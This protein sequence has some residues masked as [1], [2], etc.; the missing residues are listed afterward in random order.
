MSSRRV[1]SDQR[2]RT[3]TSCDVCKSRK[4]KCHRQPDESSCRY[5][6]VHALPCTTNQ[7]RKKRL[8]GSFESVGT[9]IQL[10]ETL[11]KGLVPE[12]DLSSLEDIRRVGSSMGIPLPEDADASVLQKHSASTEEPSTL[13]PDQQGSSQYTGPLSSYN[14]HLKLRSLL[15]DRPDPSVFKLF[16]GNASESTHP[17]EL[18]AIQQRLDAGWVHPMPSGTSQGN[19]ATADPI[20]DMTLDLRV[21]D[22]MVRTYLEAVQPDFPVLHEPTFVKTYE[23]WRRAPS[24]DDRV[25]VCTLLCMSMLASR[26]SRVE[27]TVQQQLEWWRGIQALLPTVL[28]TSSIGSVQALLLAALHLQNT[29]RRDACWN[30][31]GAAVRIAHAI[32]LHNDEIR[33]LEPPIYREIRKMVFWALFSFEQ[34]QISSYDRPSAIDYLQVKVGY[35][36]EKICGMSGCFPPDICRC[37]IQ[38]VLL[39]ACACRA[40]KQLPGSTISERVPYTPLSPAASALRDLVKW[41]ESLPPHLKLEAIDAAP[42]N[43]FRVILTLHT[44]YHYNTIV[45]SRSALLHRATLL[46]QS[47][48]APISKGL[49]T[50]SEACRDSSRAIAECML[51][52]HARGKFNCAT[53]YMSSALGL[54]LDIICSVRLG[55]DYSGQMQ[56]LLELANMA[57]HYKKTPR[58]PETLYEWTRLITEL[59]AMVQKHCSS[60]SHRHAEG[61]QRS[62]QPATQDACLPLDLR[63]QN[64]LGYQGLDPQ[65]ASGSIEQQWDPFGTGFD[66]SGDMHD[67][68]WGDIEAML[69]A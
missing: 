8:Y 62:N 9:R 41:K 18:Q 26:L 19:G 21:F 43:Y 34:I 66:T 17:L 27:V 3:E 42:P 50:M 69:N 33:T 59:A 1:A 65:M 58:T 48:S 45:L 56:I 25:W 29:A 54:V 30:L 44:L 16:G 52:M 60:Q 6:K 11:V 36:D 46:S 63:K 49:L 24:F 22:E 35:P 32:G 7:P 61:G 47:S 51:K 23:E 15:G 67:W 13:V 53:W 31:T 28:F 38:L 68:H 37:W 2:K 12:A 39:L 20:M 64:P 40:R 5:C 57:E 14:L 10:L 4:Q 55:Q